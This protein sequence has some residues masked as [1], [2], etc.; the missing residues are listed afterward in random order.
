MSLPPHHLIDDTHIALDNLH[1]LCAYVLIY[2]VR[3]RD[4]MLTVLAKLYCS[5]NCLKE[6]LLVD[7]GNDEVTLVDSL[8]TLGRGA[9]AD[10][11]EGVT[12][13]CEE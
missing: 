10:G 13:A 8:R 7:A 3:H 6:A 5:I 4:A 2:V 11:W 1:Y 9:D 12:N